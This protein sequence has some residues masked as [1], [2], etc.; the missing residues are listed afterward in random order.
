MMSESSSGCNK[1]T[2]LAVPMEL[3]NSFR[4]VPGS[5]FAGSVAPIKVR[6]FLIASGASSTMAT[7]GPD[8]LYREANSYP[9]KQLQ[10]KS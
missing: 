9:G 5:A 8:D 3:A 2:A 4:I 7:I 1:G 6:H 10:R